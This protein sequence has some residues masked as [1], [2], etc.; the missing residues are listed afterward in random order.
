MRSKRHGYK[1]FNCGQMRV[2]GCNNHYKFIL[3]A[4]A[5]VEEQSDQIPQGGAKTVTS[6]LIIPSVLAQVVVNCQAVTL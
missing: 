5:K 1:D 3:G 6:L 4:G 2:S